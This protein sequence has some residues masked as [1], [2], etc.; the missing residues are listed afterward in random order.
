MTRYISILAALWMA[1]FI[2]EASASAD[3]PSAPS[4]NKQIEDIR[5]QTEIVSATVDNLEETVSK[6]VNVSGY[7]DSEYIIDERK[8]KT[9]GFRIRHFSLFVEKKLFSDWS[10]FSELEFEDA[11]FIEATPK[12][13]EF[14]ATQG[15]ILL[16][17][18]Y[19]DYQPTHAFSLRA[20]RFLTPAGIW[21]I[22]HYPPFVTTQSRP[23]HIRN[24]FPQYED[25]LQVLGAAN[26]ADLL[27]AYMAYFANGEG[28]SG[29]GDGNDAKTFGGRLELTVP[30]AVEVKAGFSALSDTLNNGTGKTAIGADLQFR[31]SWLK[32]QSE[33]AHGRLKPSGGTPYNSIGYYFQAQADVG[34]WTFFARHDYFNPNDSI[35]DG[36]AVINSGGLNYH[37]TPTIVSK[38]EG[39]FYDSKPGNETGQNVWIF[40]LAVF[41]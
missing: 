38:I 4:P 21:N 22:N 31:V 13:G 34:K 8:G 5:D 1:L 9:D 19:A 11:P 33:Y 28:N 35:G 41:F 37:W 27:V 10:V 16:E 14:L 36:A 30:F 6:F 32:I 39:N 23:Q 40:S 7:M 26:A 24:I 20:G 29:G 15:K 3:K 12:K 25:G 2:A 17:Q 18:V